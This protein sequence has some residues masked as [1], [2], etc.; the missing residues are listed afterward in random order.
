MAVDYRGVVRGRCSSC[1]CNGYDGGSEK[2][3]CIACTHPPGKHQNL[4]TSSS[5][6]S[7]LSIS[8]MSTA[9][10]TGLFVG[11]MTCSID[12][13]SSIFMSPMAYQCQ[14]P[15]CQKES[16]FDPNTGAQNEYCHKH[17]QYTQMLSQ[18]QDS[19]NAVTTPRQSVGNN[20]SSD[21]ASSQ[22]DSSDNDQYLSCR[23]QSD[24]GSLRSTSAAP[25]RLSPSSSTNL[26]MHKFGNLFQTQMPQ[27]P[28]MKSIAQ[29]VP[30]RRK[31]MQSAGSRPAAMRTRPMTAPSQ[32]AQQRSIPA[33]PQATFMQA[34]QSIPVAQTISGA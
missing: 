19:Y 12:S 34:Q 20:D 25:P 11:E 17:I 7:S 16:A 24:G 8:S 5:S 6:V 1:V 22:S 33:M 9:S 26:G 2:K 29:H 3:K 30:P 32:Q 23:V 4:S 18:Q 21:I 13:D 15:D 27:V 28:S 10:P 31:R 14:Y